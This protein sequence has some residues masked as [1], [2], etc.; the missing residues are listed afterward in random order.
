MYASFKVDDDLVQGD[1]IQNVVITYIDSI[2]KPPIFNLEEDQDDAYQIEPN[3]TEPFNPTDKLSVMGSVAKCYSMIISQSCDVLSKDFICIARIY[4]LED[5]DK[6]YNKKTSPKT[7]AEHIKTYYQTP[8]KQPA[9]FLLQE[10]IND[11][12]PR[13]LASFVELHSIAKN[14][15]NVDYLKQNR[16]LRIN[17]EALQDLQFRLAFF[18]G[19]VAT[20]NDY[21]LTEEERLLIA[22]K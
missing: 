12:F 10:S 11:N 2:A 5:L 9:L 3:L 4:K 8:G 17:Q 13:S 14:P 15:Q 1:V 22:K 19:R 7:K 18:F 20:T 6:E 21:M 16:L